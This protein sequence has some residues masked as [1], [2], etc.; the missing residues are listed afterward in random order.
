MTAT[1]AP[2]G[3]A[4]LTITVVICAYTTDRWDL[5][6]R[7]L[8]SLDGQSRVPDEVVLVVDHDDALLH[9]ATVAF[10][11]VTVVPNT[12]R[13]G[14][15]GARN[16]GIAAASGSIVAFLDDDARADPRWIDGLL[17]AYVDSSVLGVGGAVI[18][19]WQT[20][21]PVWFP[22][23]FDWVV[24][25]SYRGLPTAVEPVRNFIGAN[26]SYRR[27]VLTTV[28]AFNSAL[29]RVGRRPLGCEE[30]EFG[31]RARRAF[32]GGRF[33]YVPGAEV[34]HHV[35]E[36]RSGWRYFLRRCWS[37][38]LSNAAV[39]RLA[40]RGEALES[41]R[42]YVA[43]VLPAAVRGGLSSPRHGGLA[44]AV[45]VIAGLAMTTGGYLRGRIGGAGT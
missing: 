21:R 5:L 45:A 1:E 35:P 43:R 37:E 2:T 8:S 40:T 36:S 38:G 4:T 11:G 3:T 44:R 25:C 23:E 31:I 28:G 32:D 41:E 10:D 29:G 42:R 20:R 26:M 18:A 15:S 16:C 9:R 7:A 27:S 24:G 12:Q 34:R 33:L 39:A 6:S 19:D 22:A 17:S 13:R 14:L 30:T